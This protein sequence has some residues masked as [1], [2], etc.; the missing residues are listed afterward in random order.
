MR[1]DEKYQFEETS[2]MCFMIYISFNNTLK[3]NTSSQFDNNMVLPLI[4][5]LDTWRFFSY[6]LS[7]PCTL[8]LYVSLMITL[9]CHEGTTIPR[10]YYP[11]FL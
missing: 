7:L 11:R 6:G 4:I 3:F 9:F 10:L 8:I 5:I 1:I 2:I